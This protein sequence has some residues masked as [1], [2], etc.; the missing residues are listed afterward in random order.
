MANFKLFSSSLGQ[1]MQT[2]LA[3]EIRIQS[4]TSTYES[5]SSISYEQHFTGEN[6]WCLLCYLTTPLSA[7]LSYEL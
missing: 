3:F 5:L 4:S 6:T 1:I 7:S 2:G